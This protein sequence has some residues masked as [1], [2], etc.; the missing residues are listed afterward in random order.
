MDSERQEQLYEQARRLKDLQK[1]DGYRIMQVQLQAEHDRVKN[2][3][4]TSKNE[5]EFMRAAFTRA[6]LEAAMSV[7]DRLL[8]G[9]VMELEQ[10]K[11]DEVV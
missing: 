8:Q 9:T 11:S 3:A 6:G 4:L 7:V 1:H 5:F 2:A 10:L